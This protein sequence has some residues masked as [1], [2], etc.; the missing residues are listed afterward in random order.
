MAHP[1]AIDVAARTTMADKP[2]KSGAARS[3]PDK[4]GEGRMFLG[5]THRTQNLD[6]ASI[7]RAFWYLATR[8]YVVAL[9][10]VG[11]TTFLTPSDCGHRLGEHLALRKWSLADA[12]FPARMIISTET[13]SLGFVGARDGAILPSPAASLAP[14]EPCSTFCAVPMHHGLRLSPFDLVGAGYRA[15]LG[16]ISYMS[17]GAREL[18]SAPKARHGNGLGALI[19]TGT[20]HG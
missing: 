19:F 17:S 18:L 16:F 11:R 20:S 15:G 14:T 12:P 3:T 6:V 2:K 8:L 1:T 7:S 10:V 9:Q 13:S 5:V 4:V